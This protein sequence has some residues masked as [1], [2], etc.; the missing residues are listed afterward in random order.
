MS[1]N[2]D[3][4][5]YQADGSVI[6]SQPLRG[7]IDG[8]YPVVLLKG[9]L[10]EE[11]LSSGRE[12]ISQLYDSAL[13]TPYVNGS[14]TLIG[15]FLVK[16]LHNVNEYF[17]AAKGAEDRAQ[18]VGFDLARQARSKLQHALGLKRFEVASETDG[19]QYASSNVRICKND[20]D[21]P[22]HN[23]NIMRDGA[24]SQLVLAKLRHQLSCVVC[25]QGT[26]DGG[27]LSIYRKP[28]SPADE[29]YKVSNGLGYDLGVVKDV[30]VHRFRPQT[31]DV[32]LLNPTYHHAVERVRGIDRITLGF[33]FG[34]FDDRLEEGVTWV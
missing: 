7:L 18:A 5:V 13:I 19:R 3:R 22:L 17:S 21:T 15:T 14:L 9:L 20:I 6:G 23:D 28:W 1:D 8:D 31:G 12:K 11:L 29:A 16:Y 33:F 25:V 2:W 24:S 27:E 30:P 4:V 34:F 26:G 10:S 32:Y